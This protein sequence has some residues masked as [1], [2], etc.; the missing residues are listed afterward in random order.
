MWLTPHQLHNFSHF[1]GTVMMIALVH[2][3]QLLPVQELGEREREKE[4]E[5]ERKW[6]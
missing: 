2:E 1:Y 3:I 4:R 5:R 6:S